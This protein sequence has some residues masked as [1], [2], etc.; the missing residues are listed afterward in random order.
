MA[1]AIQCQPS[2]H[3]EEGGNCLLGTVRDFLKEGGSLDLV[4]R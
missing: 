2:G 3:L 4:H 1:K